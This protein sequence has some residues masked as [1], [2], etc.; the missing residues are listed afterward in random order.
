M[1]KLETW[2]ECRLCGA[3]FPLD[4]AA[5]IRAH[6]RGHGK[7]DRH[8]IWRVTLLPLFPSVDFLLQKKFFDD[9]GVD[10]P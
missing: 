8:R 3:R 4:D 10:D 9:V 6:E 2:L 5:A 7:T 1:K